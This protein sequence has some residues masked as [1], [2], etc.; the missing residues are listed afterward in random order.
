M[1][2]IFYYVS[3]FEIKVFQDIGYIP[4]TI[5]LY[6]EVNVYYDLILCYL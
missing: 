3:L 2:N 4:K 1:Y 6:L 5:I